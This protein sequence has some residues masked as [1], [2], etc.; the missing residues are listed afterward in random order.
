MQYYLVFNTAILSAGVGLLKLSGDQR[1]NP[2]V[3]LVF[4]LGFVSSL[5]GSSATEAAH[6]YYR[7]ARLQKTLLEGLLGLHHSVAG[8]AHPN[9]NLAVT[10]TE[11]M[12]EAIR[13]LRNEEWSRT[14]RPLRR[15]SVVWSIVQIL[16]LFAIVNAFLV[17]YVL[18][19]HF[20]MPQRYSGLERLTIPALLARILKGPG[21]HEQAIG[22]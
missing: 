10:T 2:L 16:R 11:G 22:V 12:S 7:A 4:A 14:K 21:R 17:G 20:M 8:Y 13:D 9:A 19:N 3:A 18:Y 6:A 1:I 5:L 15:W